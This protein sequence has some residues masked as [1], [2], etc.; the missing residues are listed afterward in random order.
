MKEEIYK[1]VIFIF[2]VIYMKRN[3][4]VIKLKSYKRNKKN[5]NKKK[6]IFPIFILIMV[7]VNLSGNAILSNLN[8]EVLKLEKTLNEENIKLDQIK[9]NSYKKQSVDAIK[10][11]AEEEL[12]M[13]YLTDDSVV[14]INTGK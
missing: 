14:Y 6:I 10:Q 11:T 4:E 2:E 9:A 8:Y 5:I 1:Y 3:K 12:G 13:D 7:L